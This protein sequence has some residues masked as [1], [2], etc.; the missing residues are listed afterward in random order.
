MFNG[1]LHGG[2]TLIEKDDITKYVQSF[3]HHLYNK[4]L[5]VENNVQIKLG[6]NVLEVHLL[7]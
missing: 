2:Q 3:Y 4:D 5:K 7:W 1:L 6:N